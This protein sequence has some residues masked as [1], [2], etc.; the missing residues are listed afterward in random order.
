[1]EIQVQELG[2]S[3]AI[4]IPRSFA[5]HIQ[6]DKG[7]VIDLTLSKGIL[8]ATPIQNKRYSLA[9]LIELASVNED[10]FGE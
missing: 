2:D 8:L 5:E 1:V 4:Q 6:I 7:S 9:E 3:L 10:S